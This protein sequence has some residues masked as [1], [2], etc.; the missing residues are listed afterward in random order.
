MLRV[1]EFDLARVNNTK[2]YLSFF[3]PYV[4]HWLKNEYI[5]QFFQMIFQMH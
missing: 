3:S 4:K 1:T 2:L 5:M